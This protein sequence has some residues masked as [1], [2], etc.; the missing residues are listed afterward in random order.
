MI[1]RT[2]KPG[3][4]ATW[5]TSQWK[6]MPFPGHFSAA[7][8]SLGLG[9]ACNHATKYRIVDFI[10]LLFR[11]T[12]NGLMDSRPGHGRRFAF[13]R[14]GTL[15]NDDMI[16]TVCARSE[17]RRGGKECVSTCRSRWSPYP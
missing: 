12:D 2:P 15:T 1:P 5:V 13:C 16:L 3:V 4:S 7:I 17:E 9:Q 8:N 11:P 10:W 6:F 14:P